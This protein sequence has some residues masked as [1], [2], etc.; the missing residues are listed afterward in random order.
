MRTILRENRSRERNVMDRF[1]ELNA[2]IAVVEAGGFSAAARRTGD[3]QSA[4]SKAI[5]AL[6]EGAQILAKAMIQTPPA[7][8]KGASSAQGIVTGVGGREQAAF[9]KAFIQAMTRRHYDRETEMLPM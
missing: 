6:D 1:H 8:G 5:G 4:I 2:F 7:T 9:N 3:S